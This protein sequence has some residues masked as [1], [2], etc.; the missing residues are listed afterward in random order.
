[1]GIKSL[2][3]MSN[4]TMARAIRTKEWTDCVANPELDRKSCSA[5]VH[6][7]CDGQQVQRTGAMGEPGRIGAAKQVVAQLREELTAMI[8]ASGESTPTITSAKLYP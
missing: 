4:V 1:M 2:S 6:G 8:V 7:I 5:R 3:Q